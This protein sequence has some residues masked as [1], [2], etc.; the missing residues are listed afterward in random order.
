MLP[1]ARR[2]VAA[3]A[4]AVLCFF[5]LLG[6]HRSSVI[7]Q[8]GQRSM[9]AFH[10]QSVNSVNRVNQQAVT[11]SSRAEANHGQQND[12]VLQAQGEGYRA[13]DDLLEDDDVSEGH[14]CAGP[15]G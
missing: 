15:G 13:Q 5:V 12:R 8:L 7:G 9:L 11:A 14:D 2:M 4:A 10:H 3:M 6:C 1:A